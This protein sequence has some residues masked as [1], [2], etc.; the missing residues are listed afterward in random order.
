MTEDVCMRPV[1][2]SKHLTP[3]IDNI[4]LENIFI[5]KY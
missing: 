4:Y 2:I 1:D 3:L 5:Y